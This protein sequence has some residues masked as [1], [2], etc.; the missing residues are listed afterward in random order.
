MHDHKVRKFSS[1][2]A[3]CLEDLPPDSEWQGTKQSPGYGRTTGL[4]LPGI[5]RFSVRYRSTFHPGRSR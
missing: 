3:I 2:T 5:L 4:R 1:F